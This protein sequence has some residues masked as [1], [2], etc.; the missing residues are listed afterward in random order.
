ML[1][2]LASRRNMKSPQI[3]ELSGIGDPAILKKIGVLVKVNLPGVG[4]NVQDHI[5]VFICMGQF[6]NAPLSFFV[7]CLRAPRAER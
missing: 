1:A 5:L 2:D 7:I 4:T 6:M 3:L